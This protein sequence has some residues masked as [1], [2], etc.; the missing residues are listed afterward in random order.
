MNDGHSN[1]RLDATKSDQ[2]SEA[3]F[4]LHEYQNVD[5]QSERWM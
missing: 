2:L 5:Q 1:L 3:K 4:I